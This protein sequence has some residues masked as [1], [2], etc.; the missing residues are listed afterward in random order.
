[1][2]ISSAA[3]GKLSSKFIPWANKKDWAMSES[4]CK[5]QWVKIISAEK[6]AWNCFYDTLDMLD[7]ELLSGSKKATETK[8]EA[9]NIIDNC[10]INF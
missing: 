4:L 9:Q 8:N 2:V 3:G 1:M 7:K 5:N 10:K 6:N